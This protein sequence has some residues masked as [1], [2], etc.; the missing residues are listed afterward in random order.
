MNIS[1]LLTPA[2]TSTLFAPLALGVAFNI[3]SAI[4]P[5]SAIAQTTERVNPLEDLDSRQN[6]RDSLTGTP[7][8]SGFNVFDFI[9]RSR[10][11]VD[12]EAFNSELDQNL[13]NATQEFRQ[14]QR[15][16]LRNQPQ[17]QPNSPSV[18]TGGAT[19]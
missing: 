11:G 19:R 16:R 1:T 12:S 6:E 9:H 8:N 10:L 2:L 13:D 5:E 18:P 17:V 7:G 3:P 14:L 4:I 15:E